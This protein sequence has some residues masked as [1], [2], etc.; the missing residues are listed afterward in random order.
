MAKFFVAVTAVLMMA[1]CSCNKDAA[2]T[3]APAEATAEAPA[4]GDAAAAP[5]DAAT[6]PTETNPETMGTDPMA[7]ATPAQ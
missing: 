1:G 7:S 5:V 6:A 3:D 4:T 2:T